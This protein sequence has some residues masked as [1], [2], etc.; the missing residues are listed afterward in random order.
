MSDLEF[1]DGGIGLGFG[2][3]ECRFCGC[4]LVL[5]PGCEFG[6]FGFELGVGFCNCGLCLGV[7]FSQRG[8]GFGR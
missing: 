2:L 5:V 7:G 8:L 4:E 1:G 3:G 6:D